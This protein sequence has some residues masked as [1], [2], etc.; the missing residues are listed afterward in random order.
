M[1]IMSQ[2]LTSALNKRFSRSDQQYKIKKINLYLG[3][4]NYPD[5]IPSG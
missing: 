5:H 4:A 3:L 1:Q 2:Y